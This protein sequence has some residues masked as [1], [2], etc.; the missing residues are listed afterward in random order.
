MSFVSTLI[1][2]PV[3]SRRWND[4]VPFSFSRSSPVCHLACANSDYALGT[5]PLVE[6]EA[7]SSLQVSFIIAGTIAEPLS[8]VGSIVG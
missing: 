6:P 8:I 3:V 2:A 5:L 4:D 7:P 1:D